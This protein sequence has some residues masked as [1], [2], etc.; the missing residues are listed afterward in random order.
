MANAHGG[1]E[2]AERFAAA[3]VEL[4]TRLNDDAR[5]GVGLAP[6]RGGERGARTGDHSP[7]RRLLGRE[8]PPVG[9]LA[10]LAQLDL[11][12]QAAVDHRLDLRERERRALP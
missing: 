2:P 8:Q 7:E 10:A 3:A 12:L 5:G 11:R 6:A 4:I 1:A 9:G